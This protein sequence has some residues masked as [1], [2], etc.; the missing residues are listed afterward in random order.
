MWGFSGGPSFPL[1]G[2]LFFWIP[3]VGGLYVWGGLSGGTSFQVCRNVGEVSFR[4][5]FFI[6]CQLV[7]E[8]KRNRGKMSSSHM[9][10]SQPRGG[11]GHG[12]ATTHL[13][14]SPTLRLAPLT[15]VGLKNR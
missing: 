11:Q 3:W 10:S 9:F 12:L 4:P 6:F 15:D 8:V 5:I 7:R 14:R 13:Q 1:T 2:L